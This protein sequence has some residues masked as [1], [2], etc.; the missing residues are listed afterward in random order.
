MISSTPPRATVM[1]ASRRIAVAAVAAISLAPAIRAASAQP[2]ELPSPKQAQQ[3]CSYVATRGPAIRSALVANG[4]LDANNDGIADDVRVGRG[5][6]TAGGDVLEIRPRGASQDS[7]P[8]EVSA[9]GWEWKDYW[10]YGARWLRYGG[11]AYTLY[12][13]AETLRN[14][15]ALGYIDK[16]NREHIVC[17]FSSVEDERLVPVSNDATR[18]CGRMPQDQVHYIEP[19]KADE[20][21]PRR[22]TRL[23]GRLRVDFRNNGTAEELALL[24]YDS[25]AARGC[26]F[27][28][29]DTISA[30]RLGQNGPARSVL[31]PAQKIDLRGQSLKEY[32]DPS[33][34]KFTSYMDPPHCGD[35]TPRWFELGGKI[36][37]DESA[38][39]DDGRLPRFREITLIRRQSITLQ[40]RS[41]YGVRWV[42]K[43]MARPFD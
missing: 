12:F 43:N 32:S 20:A 35:V 28:Y 3:V 27:K 29:Y 21:T 38:A 22:E 1:A 41:E 4:V 31:L 8:I 23:V 2:A 18:L 5:M 7:E 17:A 9:V 34:G 13:A 39:R 19:A 16:H 24:S 6:G 14:A 42:V 36:Y 15:V 37:L 30:D 40:C 25:G 11:R 10:A 33:E 26:D